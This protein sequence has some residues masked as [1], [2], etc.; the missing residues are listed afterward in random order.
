MNKKQQE[1]LNLQ[2]LN[3]MKTL[4]QKR[5]QKVT[6]EKEGNWY[7]IFK[8]ITKQ[9]YGKQQRTVIPLVCG[10]AIGCGIVKIL[11]LLCL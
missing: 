10:L 4:M 1:S 3:D 9:L 2:C 11:P 8:T 5:N 7:E 6:K